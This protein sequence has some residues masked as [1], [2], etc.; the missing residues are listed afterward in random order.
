[1]ML[2]EIQKIMDER[3]IEPRAFSMRRKRD[4][5]TPHTRKLSFYN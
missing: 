4:T 2:I 5:S 3:G 1:M